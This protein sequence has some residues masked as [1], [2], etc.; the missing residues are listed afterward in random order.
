MAGLLLCKL[1]IVIP[2]FMIAPFPLYVDE[3]SSDNIKATVSNA[4][5]VFHNLRIMAL[6]MPVSFMPSKETVILPVGRYICM[7][8][9]NNGKRGMVFLDLKDNRELAERMAEKL[10]HIE[11]QDRFMQV[12]REIINHPENH[13][14]F[15]LVVGKVED[16]R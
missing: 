1:G 6:D 8:V 2:F 12:Y 9:W 4:E 15:R 11:L 13:R 5:K 7:L 10:N 16:I 14:K 3:I